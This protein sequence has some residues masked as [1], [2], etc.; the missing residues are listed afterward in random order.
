MSEF[1]PRDPAIKAAL[2]EALREWLDDMFATFGRWTLTGLA[3]AAFGGMVY[4]ALVGA[5][6]KK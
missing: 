4:L 6:W 3:V 5:G 2:K 1:D